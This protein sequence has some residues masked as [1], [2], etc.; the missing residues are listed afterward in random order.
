MNRPLIVGIAGGLV[1][2]AAILLTFFIDREPD[3]PLPPASQSSELGGR[4][5]K[6]PVPTKT[7]TEVT[8]S[9]KTNNVLRSGDKNKAKIPPEKFPS[10][11]KVK[12]SFDVVR[13]NPQ[14]NT[15]IAGR[16]APN[17]VVTVRQGDNLV[18]TVKADKR[19]EWVL[20]PEK[21]LAAGT[22]ELTLVAK[23]PNGTE[24]PSEKVVVV[25]VPEKGRD[26]SGRTTA[27]TA[28]SLAVAIPKTPDEAPVLL[29]RPDGTI[30]AELTLDVIDY[31]QSGDTL[32]LSGRAKPDNEVRVYL[33]NKFIGRAL[34]DDKGIWRLKPD[35]EIQPGLYRMRVD[36]VGDGG[37]TL[38]RVELPFLRAARLADL[39]DGQIALVQPGNSLWRLARKTYG[40]G[41][42]YTEIYEANKGQIRDPDLIYPGQVFILPNIK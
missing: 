23:L 22:H 16:A 34:A 41:L 8:A 11:N 39:P 30:A 21:R 15:V 20:L 19:G 40:S 10:N 26:I 38:A 28:G 14:G 31:G 9:P 5:T 29:Q 32:S 3:R 42:R 18:G 13:V 2:L 7:E 25:V 24:V 37:K 35:V 6:T 4:P 12:P 1:V 27:E 33:N 36:R 17:S